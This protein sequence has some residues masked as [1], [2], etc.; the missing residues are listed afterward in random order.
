MKNLDKEENFNKIKIIFENK[1]FLVLN[2]PAGLLVQPV[3]E[4]GEKTLIDWLLKFRPEIKEIGGDKLRPGLVHRLD[5]EVSGLMVIAKT[6][7]F[8]EWIKNQFKDHQVKKEYLALVHGQP[9]KRKNF[10][11]LPLTKIKGATTLA[12]RIN[13][14]RIKEAWTEYEVLKTFQK[15]SLLKIKTKTGRTH[16]IRVHLKSIGHP[17]VGDRKYKIKRQKIIHLDQ[18]I[19]L[20]AFK[21]GFFDFSKRWQEFQIDLPEELKN[22]LEK[23][24]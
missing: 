22:F 21:L 12:R 4:M 7:E 18:R 20:H 24:E 16:Q 8:F 6:Q 5:Q 11:I 10:I 19:F 23:I 13:L 14:E 1:D 9:A 17:I 2:K 3:K 15:F